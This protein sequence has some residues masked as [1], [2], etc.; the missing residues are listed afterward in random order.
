VAVT[1]LTQ[2]HIGI[3]S[4]FLEGLLDSMA[5]ET[6]PVYTINYKDVLEDGLK[7][8]NIP[9]T[10]PQI[11]EMESKI[12]RLLEQMYGSK[13]VYYGGTEQS[14][15][16]DGQFKTYHGQLAIRITE[17]SKLTYDKTIRVKFQGKEF[18]TIEEPH[19][20]DDETV[21]KAHAVDQLDNEYLIEWEV[22]R[23]KNKKAGY[24]CDWPNPVKVESI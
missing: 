14:I 10:E 7:D 24:I 2:D 15:P 4:R 17:F 9:Y 3:M 18:R 1:F 21:C 16:I 20:N 23:L 5:E 22:I 12:R 8:E 11:F 19:F 13:N 6:G